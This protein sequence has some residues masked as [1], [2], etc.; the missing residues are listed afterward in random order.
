[1]IPTGKRTILLLAIALIIGIG[2]LV[3]V[4][5]RY[6]IQELVQHRS[7]Q[8]FGTQIEA[9]NLEVSIYSTWPELK[10]HLRQLS[11][12]HNSAIQIHTA[13][14]Q[15][16]L[17]VDMWDLVWHNTLTIRHITLSEATLHLQSH[18]GVRYTLDHLRL[19][20]NIRQLRDTLHIGLDSLKARLSI[21]TSNTPW[22]TRL[23]L[24]IKSD[25]KHIPQTTAWTLAKSDIK[26]GRLNWTAAGHLLPQDT[27]TH[28]DLSIQTIQANLS[29]LISILKF[30]PLPTL[31]SVHSKGSLS[32]YLRVNG[33]WNPEQ[34]TPEIQADLTLDQ[35]WIKHPNAPQAID[36]LRLKLLLKKPRS[37]HLDSLSLQIAL[38]AATLENKVKAHGYIQHLKPYPKIYLNAVTSLNLDVLQQ[39]LPLDKPSLHLSGKWHSNI[40]TVDTLTLSPSHNMATLRAKI[41]AS[42]LSISRYDRIHHQLSIPS[43]QLVLQANRL[44]GKVGIQY[45]KSNLWAKGTLYRLLP[46]L[47]FDTKLT[48][49]LSLKSTHMELSP[50][51]DT[52]TSNNS[53]PSSTIA[54]VVIDATNTSREHTP[55]TPEPLFT[56]SKPYDLKLDLDLQDL[57]YQ[58]FKAKALSGRAHLHGHSLILNQINLKAFGGTLRINGEM[59]PTHMRTH[60]RLTI[61]LHRI[62]LDQLFIIPLFKSVYN[63]PQAILSGNM[64]IDALHDKALNIYYP[65]LYSKGNL[66]AQAL[67]WKKLEVVNRLNT[68]IGTRFSNHVNIPKMSIDYDINNGNMNLNSSPFSIEHIRAN[69]GGDYSFISD[70]IRMN[71]RG[72]WVQQGELKPLNQLLEII[73]IHPQSTFE[74]GI[75][76]TLKSPN[77]T[78]GIKR[79]KTPAEKKTIR[80]LLESKEVK[81][82]QQKIKQGLKDLFKF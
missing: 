76:N 78:I 16:S 61:G 46:H 12:P 49:Q 20:A 28:I 81:Q 41:A 55:P 70:S 64:A 48:G 56:W 57:S 72:Q 38:A 19:D 3:P 62:D 53:K 60:S 13:I 7:T 22:L 32:A 65:S 2:S 34:S 45:N 54:P 67:K 68:R 29:E 69:F 59:T 75:H 80:E 6:R 43:I 51:R 8:L 40:H 79:P 17:S 9:P 35:G 36:S 74:I 25:L 10:V 42:K 58:T 11:L 73:G 71:I 26:L 27:T 82:L 39:I 18:S 66:T 50:L 14:P 23:P 21:A 15:L 5:M 52:P 47:L 4:V 24:Y 77:Y 31:A 30:S 1:M 33:L 37:V 44:A 63:K